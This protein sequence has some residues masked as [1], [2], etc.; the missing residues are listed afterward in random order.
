MKLFS[1]LLL[2]LC[3][4]IGVIFQRVQADHDRYPGV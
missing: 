1:V 2:V 3:A 4:E